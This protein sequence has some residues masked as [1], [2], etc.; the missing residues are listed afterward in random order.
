MAVLSA[1]VSFDV[2]IAC[3]LVG[4]DAEHVVDTPAASCTGAERVPASVSEY[5][6]EYQPHRLSACSSSPHSKYHTPMHR[7]FAGHS[8]YSEDYVP[9]SAERRTLACAHL[10]GV[11]TQQAVGM[12]LSGPP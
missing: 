1:Q 3:L 11:R 8:T 10:P 5:D 4:P 6:A 2:N 7:S 12:E 9:K